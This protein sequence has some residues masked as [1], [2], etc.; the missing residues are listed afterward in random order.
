M[1]CCSRRGNDRTGMPDQQARM[2]AGAT[3]RELISIV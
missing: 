1:S 3:R 2:V